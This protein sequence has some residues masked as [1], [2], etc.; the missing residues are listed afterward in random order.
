MPVT[1]DFTLGHVRTTLAELDTLGAGS[2]L[3]LA[4]GSPACVTIGAGGQVL[5]RGE[6]VEVDGRLGVRIVQWG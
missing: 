3:T 6:A 1:L 2:V 4:D 5:G